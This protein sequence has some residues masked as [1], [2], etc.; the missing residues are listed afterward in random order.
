MSA[1]TN[2]GNEWFMESLRTEYIDKSGLIAV[3]NSTLFTE[4]RY[5]CV[6]RCRRFG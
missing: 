2:K 5:S 1:F 6:T 3:V 4:N